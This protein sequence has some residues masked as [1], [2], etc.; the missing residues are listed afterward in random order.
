MGLCFLTP[1]LRAMYYGCQQERL[2]YL[3]WNVVS[4]CKW[5]LRHD[6]LRARINLILQGLWGLL[7]N[8]KQLEL[9]VMVQRIVPEMFT[10]DDIF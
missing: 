2:L 8:I 4:V 1:H 9:F 3:H 6:F 5:K 10:R 7:T